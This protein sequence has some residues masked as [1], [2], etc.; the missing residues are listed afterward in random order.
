MNIFVIPSWFPSKDRPLSGTMIQ[1][2]V[3]AFCQFYPSVNV[4]V[5]IWGQQ[6]EDYLLWTKDHFRNLKKILTADRSPYQAR[7]LP[8]LKVYH[9]PAFTWTRKFLNG[10]TRNIIQANIRNLEAFEAE[11]GPVDLIHAHVGYPAG[12]I[13][14]EVAEK[15][16]KPYCLTERMGPFPWVHTVDKSGFLTDYY[17]APYLK[18]AVNIAVSPFQAEMMGKQGIDNIKVI[19]NFVNEKVFIPAPEKQPEQEPY[20]FFSLSYIA[21][22][23]GTDVVVRAAGELLRKYK[24]VK[25]RMGGGGPFLQSC[26]TLAAELGIAEHFTWL[27][28]TD[29][30]TALH[31]FQ[32]CDAFVLASQ[33]ESMGIVY[34]EAIACGKPIIATKCGGPETTVTPANGLLVEKDNRAAL[35]QAMEH[36]MTHRHKYNSAIIREDFLR[37]F[38]IQSVVPRLYDLYHE[39]MEG[40]STK[41]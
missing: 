38:S 15:R 34:V 5:S 1:E 23:K 9:S 24:N 25:F 6:E 20:T 27:G 10:N 11:H 26:Q 17:R 28:D 19:P 12:I 33:Y 2:Q 8:N 7:L 22:N 36:I 29:R 37:R 32:K 16:N 13:A 41:A 3:E 39:V 30:E 4:G 14:M 35:A 18:A 21:P 31:E 40:K